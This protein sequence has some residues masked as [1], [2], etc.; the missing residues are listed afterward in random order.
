MQTEI[1]LHSYVREIRYSIHMS[2]NEQYSP[3]VREVAAQWASALIW[4][5]RVDDYRA[6]LVDVEPKVTW[7]VMAR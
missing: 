1:D 4:S 6:V 2:R 7:T 3:V 5:Y